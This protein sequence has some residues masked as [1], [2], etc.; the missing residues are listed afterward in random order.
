[1]I[2]IED[3]SKEMLPYVR[4]E[5]VP[6]RWPF[7][8]WFEINTWEE[9]EQDGKKFFCWHHHWRKDGRRF[10]LWRAH[11]AAHQIVVTT[12]FDMI[13]EIEKKKKEGG[14]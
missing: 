1:M 9:I 2:Y 12:W 5:L 6:G 3:G 14:V 7:E 11:R 10:G 4:A 8:W 13:D